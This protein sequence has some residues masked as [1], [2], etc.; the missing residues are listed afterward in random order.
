MMLLLL[1]LLWLGV[2]TMTTT[3]AATMVATAAPPAGAGARPRSC[4]WMER[5]SSAWRFAFALVS[6]WVGILTM[7]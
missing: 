5:V 1:R 6:A 3:T 4:E 2:A 7:M